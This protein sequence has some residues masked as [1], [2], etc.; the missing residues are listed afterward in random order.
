MIND[1]NFD[2]KLKKAYSLYKKQNPKWKAMFNRL[3]EFR[4]KEKSGTKIFADELSRGPE[5]L[6]FNNLRFIIMYFELFSHNYITR[7][8]IDLY[9]KHTTSNIVKDFRDKILQKKFKNSPIL[10]KRL[11]FEPCEEDEE[12]PIGHH[13]DLFKDLGLDDSESEDSIFEN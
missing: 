12:E 11:S 7:A 5:R 1:Q 3:S 13:E 4:F 9:F 10:K 8:D 6:V 2:L